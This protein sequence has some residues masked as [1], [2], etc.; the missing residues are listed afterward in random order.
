[1]CLFQHAPATSHV[2][3]VS[4][5]ASGVSKHFFHCKTIQSYI[6]SAQTVWP[7]IRRTLGTPYI[8]YRIWHWATG[9]VTEIRRIYGHIRRIYS[10]W[11]SHVRFRPTLVIHRMYDVQVGQS[12]ASAFTVCVCFCVHVYFLL[13]TQGRSKN[14][15]IREEAEGR[16]QI[17]TWEWETFLCYVVER[18]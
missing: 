4:L 8:R 13:K 7:Y 1:M 6:G 14:K 5:L 15:E 12:W 16:V 3:D 10:I 11:E 2:I 18:K 17:S 9:S